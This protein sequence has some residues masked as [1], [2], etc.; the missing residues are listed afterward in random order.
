MTVDPETAPAHRQRDGVDYWFCGTG[1][2]EAFDID[3]DRYAG[4]QPSP[5]THDHR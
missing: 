4:D 3:P 5:R 2:A 1:C